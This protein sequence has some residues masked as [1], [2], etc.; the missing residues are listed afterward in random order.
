MMLMLNSAFPLA[1]NEHERKLIFCEKNVRCL[2]EKILERSVYLVD[3]YFFS[4]SALRAL[5]RCTLEPEMR[6]REGEEARVA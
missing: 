1:K 5:N 2:G 3:H 4:P 6:G